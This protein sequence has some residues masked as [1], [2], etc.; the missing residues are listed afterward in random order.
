MFFAALVDFVASVLLGAFVDFVASVLFAA[1]AFLAVSVLLDALVDLDASVS[2]SYTHLDVYKRQVRIS[3][4]SEEGDSSRH[5]DFPRGEAAWLSSWVII[6]VY[7]RVFN[8][9][10]FIFYQ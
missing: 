7:S 3:S 4:R 2:V 5:R 1:F 9:F 8:A 10:W 6:F